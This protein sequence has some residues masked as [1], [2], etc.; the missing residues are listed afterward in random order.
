MLSLDIKQN[1][2]YSGHKGLHHFI[3]SVKFSFKLPNN[4]S[5]KCALGHYQ[6]KRIVLHKIDSSLGINLLHW[7]FTV[8]EKWCGRWCSPS[9]VAANALG[10]YRRFLFISGEKNVGARLAV[11]FWLEKSWRDNIKT[12]HTVENCVWS[13]NEWSTYGEF[14]KASWLDLSLEPNEHWEN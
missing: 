10:G 2:R 6:K 3:L 13:C 14:L 1:N 4:Q 12:Q 9:I 8:E 5:K 11:L 7:A